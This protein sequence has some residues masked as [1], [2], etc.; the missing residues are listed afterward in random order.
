MPQYRG[1]TV[2]REM[3]ACF[4]LQIPQRLSQVG[5]A[6]HAMRFEQNAQQPLSPGGDKGKSVRQQNLS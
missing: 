4:G 5:N 6:L 1:N 3:K 2:I